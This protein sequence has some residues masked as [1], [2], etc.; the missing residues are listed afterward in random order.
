MDLHLTNQM[1]CYIHCICWLMYYLHVY[2]NA[3]QVKYDIYYFRIKVHPKKNIDVQLVSGVDLY[4]K[5]IYLFQELAQT[6]VNILVPYWVFFFH[7]ISL[8]YVRWSALKWSET[9]V[10][11]I[12]CKLT[13]YFL[14]DMSTA[15]QCVLLL[16]MCIYVSLCCMYSKS[17]LTV[18]HWNAR[19]LWC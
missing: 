10:H 9:Y 12:L 7:G 2:H 16:F 18:V 17:S 6:D 4:V 8:A 14:F 11:F 15:L 19:H 5:I 1:K 3:L 13:F